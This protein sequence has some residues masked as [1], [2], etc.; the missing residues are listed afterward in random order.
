MKSIVQIRAMPVRTPSPP[1]PVMRS[2]RSPGADVE[3]DRGPGVLRGRP[4][5][6]PVGVGEPGLAKGLRLAAEEHP[7]VPRA[8]A[9][10]DLAHGGLHVPERRRHDRDQPLRIRTAP[11]DQEVV[12]GPH[13]LEHELRLFQIQ[14]TPRAEAAHVRVEDLRVDALPVHV[15]ESGLRVVGGRDGIREGVG[16]IRKQAV[17]LGHGRY[18]RRLEQIVPRS[19][20][21]PSRSPRDP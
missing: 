14:K 5:R 17:E 11:V 20:R 12:V 1:T 15:L 16:V 19:P 13:A 18:G 10:L 4:D 9:A 7:P 3:A 21:S 8:G 6:V 2:L